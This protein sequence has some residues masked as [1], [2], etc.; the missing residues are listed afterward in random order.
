LAAG[1]NAL[2]AYASDGKIVKIK[3]MKN[4]VTG[5]KG[6]VVYHLSTG[7]GISAE[8]ELTEMAMVAGILF[9]TSHKRPVKLKTKDGFKQYPNMEAWLKTLRDSPTLFNIVLK[10]CIKRGV[11]SGNNIKADGNWED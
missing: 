8:V 10:A 11:S 7:Q 3:S 6:E 4:K 5:K 1:N 9:N 2:W